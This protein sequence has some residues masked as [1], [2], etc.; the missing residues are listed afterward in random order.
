MIVAVI[1][2]DALKEVK[3]LVAVELAMEAKVDE[4]ALDSEVSVEGAVIVT[5]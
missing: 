1:V 3:K 4:T 2:A 5:D